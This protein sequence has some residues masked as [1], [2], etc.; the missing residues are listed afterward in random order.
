M[1]R[2]L[3]LGCAVTLVTVGPAPSHYLFLLPGENGA[4][5]QL[6]WND[7]PI[8]EPATGLDTVSTG[9]FTAL[10][11]LGRA[12]S[13]TPK[14]GGEGWL[15]FDGLPADAREVAGTVEYGVVVRGQPEPVLVIHHAK[16]VLT[17][18]T[19]ATVSTARPEAMPAE[20]TPVVQP[21][22]IAFRLTVG[23]KKAASADVLVQLPDEKRFRAV[24]TDAD[25]LT[26]AFDRAGKYAARALVTEAKAG[27]FRGRKY[28]QVRHY[29]TLVVKYDSGH[30]RQ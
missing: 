7:G 29:P 15:G 19:P 14:P 25:G 22:G 10:D 12:V 8:S 11:G 24:R 17:P 20:L 16:T 6:V 18:V 1:R 21:G 2:V 9:R 3:T 13:V 30:Q 26:P 27:E 28:Q 4:A 5:P 23:G